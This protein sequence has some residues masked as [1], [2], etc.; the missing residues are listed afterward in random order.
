MA[1]ANKRI[2][3]AKA[4]FYP[5]FSIG[6]SAGYQNTGGPAWMSQPNSFWSIGPTGTFNLFDSGLREAQVIQAKAALD[7]AAAE[8]RLVVLTAFQ[9][10]EDSVNKLREYKE[11]INDRA[12]AAN[13]ALRAM[14]LATSRYK[15]GAVN[16]LEVV[17]A[18]TA[19]LQAERS[20]ITLD[21]ARRL[22]S[23]QLIKALGGGWSKESLKIEQDQ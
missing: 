13:A 5:S 4:S 18:Q 17:T 10:V 22:T 14:Q 2:G 15:D 1:A 3:V 19:A 7:Q 6:A 16:Y 23:I 12:S 9:Q 11:E 20:Y 21:T 8:Y